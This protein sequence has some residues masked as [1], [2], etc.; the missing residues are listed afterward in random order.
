MPDLVESWLELTFLGQ[1]VR[2]WLVALGLAFGFLLLVAIAKRLFARRLASWASRTATGI[3][4]FLVA[5]ATRTRWLLMLFPAAWLG[6]LALDL[7]PKAAKAA[8]GLRVAAILAL[9]VQA[10]LWGVVAIDFWMARHRRRRLETDAASAAL[11]GVLGFVAKVALWAVLLLLGLDNVGVKVTAAV[12]GLGIGG[13]AVA[14]AVQNVLGDLLASL[15]IALDKPFVIGDTIQVGDLVGKVEHVG[16]KTTRLRSVS[17]E[18]LVFANSDLLGSRI[19]NHQ[20]LEERRVTL[21]FGVVRSTPPATLARIPGLVRGIV[22]S[23]DL[24]RFDHAHLV[25]LGESALEFEVVWVVLTPD[26]AVH[27][28]RQQAILLALLEALAADGVELALPTRTLFLEDRADGGPRG[29]DDAR[30]P[31]PEDPRQPARGAE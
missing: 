15:S 5:L 25:R 29:E 30:G 13:I 7:G 28:D 22:E 31:E 19:R 2:A 18:Q 3:D 11:I 27:L 1:A 12:A 24:V 9:V 20:R 8:Q 6:S 26:H 21:A 10:A 14:L 16:L 17:G 23:Q 4:D